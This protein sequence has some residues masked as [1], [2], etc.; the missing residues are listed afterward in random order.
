MRAHLG[1]S[2]MPQAPNVLPL[3]L[4]LGILQVVEGAPHAK[5][6]VAEALAEFPAAAE[7]RRAQSG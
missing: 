3:L 4:V 7:Q 6:R 5:A 2:Y 1:V